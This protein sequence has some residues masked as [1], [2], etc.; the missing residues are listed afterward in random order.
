MF[1]LRELIGELLRCN[2]AVLGIHRLLIGDAVRELDLLN[3]A[4][5]LITDGAQYTR[6]RCL[7]RMRIRDR[8]P[9]FIIDIDAVG[10]CQCDIRLLEHFIRKVTCAQDRLG[11]VIF[12]E[13]EAAAEC[14][15]LPLLRAGKPLADKLLGSKIIRFLRDHAER[16]AIYRNRDAVLPVLELTHNTEQYQTARHGNRKPQKAQ[17]HALL[18]EQ[19]L[20]QHPQN[21]DQPRF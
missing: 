17:Q 16:L 1:S 20:A 19:H 9:E 2:Q 6:K 8:A 18:S 3:L 15:I 4:V 14:E 11:A 5:I 10:F 21:G 13:L 7:D 12:L